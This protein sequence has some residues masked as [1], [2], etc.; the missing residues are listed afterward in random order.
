MVEFDI[1]GCSR[2]CASTDREI[3]RGEY[4][5][6][7]V[8]V[9]DKEITRLDYCQEAWPGPPDECLGW[10]KSQVPNLED[11]KVYWAPNDVLYSYF[12]GILAENQEPEKLYVMALLMVRKRLMKLDDRE[13]R[14]QKKLWLTSSRHDSVIEVGVVDLSPQRIAALQNELGEHLFTNRVVGEQEESK[15]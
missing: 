10:W 1:K 4:Y 15:D 7:V 13:T 5:Y 3:G 2:K 11:G 6:S 12:D 9:Q 8:T 14:D